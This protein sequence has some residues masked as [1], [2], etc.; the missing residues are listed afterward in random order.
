MNIDKLDDIINGY[1]NQYHRAI[2]M[3]PVDVNA[4]IDIDFNVENDNK[5]PKFEAN[6]A[7]HIGMKKLL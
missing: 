3:K 1:G 6:E 4:S 5:Y 7:L 2:K